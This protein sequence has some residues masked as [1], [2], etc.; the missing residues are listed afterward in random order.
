MAATGRRGVQ[1]EEVRVAMALNGGVSLAVWRGGCAVELACARRAHLGPEDAGT[2]KRPAPREVY[3]AICEAFG[4]ELV[5]DILTGASAGGINGALLAGTMRA[6]RRLPPEL[7]RR[8]WLDLGDFSK[9]LYDTGLPNP[10]AIM[11][12]KVF[13]EALEGMFRAVLGTAEADADELEQTAPP[14]TQPGLAPYPAVLDVTITNVMGEP[15]AFVD[16]WDEQLSAREYRGLIRF[17]SDADFTPRTLADAARTS[18]SFPVA[19]PPFLVSGQSAELAKVGGPRWAIDGGLLEN[20]PISV[21]LELIPSRP[22]ARRVRRF[23]CYVNAHPPRHE[24]VPDNLP[25]PTLAQVVGHVVNI[26]RDARFVDQLDAIEQAKRRGTFSRE[27][28][29]GLLTLD[30]QALRETA[31]SLLEPYRR[32]RFLLSLED[33]LGNAGQARVVFERLGAHPGIP[34][35]PPDLTPPLTAATWRWGMKAAER[36]LYLQLDVLRDAYA[37][38]GDEEARGRILDTRI[39]IDRQISVL[40]ALCRNFSSDGSVRAILLDLVDDEDPDAEIAALGA[41]AAEYGGKVVAAVRT[42]TD[43]LHSVAADLGEPVAAALFGAGASEDGLDDEAF[44]NFLTRALSIE[45][46]RRAFYT[47]QEIDTG[48]HLRFA[49]LTP[50]APTWIFTSKPL[51]ERGPDSPEDKLTG[52]GLGHFAG[53]Y[54]RSWRANDFMWGRL[55][56][57]TR[58]VDMLVDGVRARELVGEGA[59]APWLALARTLAPEGA[60][61]SAVERRRLVH[62]ALLDARAGADGLAPEVTA[63]LADYAIG[64]AEPPTEELVSALER[65]LEADLRADDRAMLTR[66]L[67]ARAVQLEIVRQEVPVVVG[68][69]RGD[70]ALGAFTDPL[71]LPDGDSVFPAIERLREQQLPVMLG[72]DSPD[73]AASGLALGT[74]SHAGMVA[75]SALRTADIPLS[76]SLAIVRA[77]LL[78]LSG[79]ASQTRW[80][81]LA[82]VLGLVAAAFYIAARLV[83]SSGEAA[84]LGTLWSP[85]VWL[86]WIAILVVAGVVGVPALRAWRSQRT[87]WRIE[88]SLWALLLLAA[89]VGIAAALAKLEGGLGFAD[90]LVTPGA[91]EPRAVVVWFALGVVLGLQLLRLGWLPSQIVGL[92]DRVLRRLPVALLAAAAAAT[93]LVWSGPELWDAFRDGETWQQAAACAAAASLPVGLLYLVIGNRR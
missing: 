79:I 15:R 10:D 2:E 61:T 82:V 13:H 39:V 90:L 49:Q 59:A 77:I 33:V 80:I 32:R 76:G 81:R 60:G 54:R 62:E 42:A 74:I 64:G 51:R 71:T 22:A 14:P 68:E 73:E 45:V 53:F 47:D 75:V 43:A 12:G 93:T 27:N 65:A 87:A 4:R 83:T 11:Q 29:L 17:R 30:L 44:A 36:V 52:I 26:P 58:I 23:V 89:G 34:W 72:R 19:F 37:A 8:K 78:P 56:A 70:R 3:H 92:A 21:A 57:A 38:A 46:V 28:Q 41:L 24:P 48:Q 18:A 86:Y 50:V 6:G 69:S 9:L 31:Q 91:E 85:P 88:Q 66:V 25:A 67:C 7:L 35:L 16:D 1:V 84:P 63:S 20:A 55:D 40:E 5:V